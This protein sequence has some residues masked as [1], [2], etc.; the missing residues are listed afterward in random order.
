MLMAGKRCICGC[1]CEKALEKIVVRGGS[2]VRIAFDTGQR[3]VYLPE[4]WP[5]GYG[6]WPLSMQVA[7]LLPCSLSSV[8]TKSNDSR[9]LFDVTGPDSMILQKRETT[10]EYVHESL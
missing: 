7:I 5:S 6:F 9:R 10:T 1:E 8:C 2:P 3:L 4:V